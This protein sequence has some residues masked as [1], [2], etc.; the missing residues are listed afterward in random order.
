MMGKSLAVGI[1]V[2]MAAFPLNCL[3]ASPEVSDSSY[4]SKL[5]LEEN[6]IV[7]SVLYIPYVAFQI[8]V[9]LIDGIINPKPASQSTIPPPAHRG[10]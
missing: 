6:S 7:A 9:R 8:P 1:C 10:H 3:A 2:L 4:W 5:V